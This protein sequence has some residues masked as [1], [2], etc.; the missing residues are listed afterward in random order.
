MQPDNDPVIEEKNPLAAKL[1]LILGLAPQLNMDC[2]MTNDSEATNE[3][4]KMV[5][6]SVED[7]I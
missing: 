3:L 4:L 7:V 5:L 6:M 1:A 2:L